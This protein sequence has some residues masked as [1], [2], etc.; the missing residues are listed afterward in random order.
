MGCFVGCFVLLLLDLLIYKAE[1]GL[2]SDCSSS[3]ANK[4]HGFVLK[5]RRLGL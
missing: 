4:A 2:L 5:I 3:I 1:R